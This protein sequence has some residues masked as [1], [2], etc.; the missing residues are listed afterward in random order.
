MLQVLAMVVQVASPK[1]CK[2]VSCYC[3]LPCSD[4]NVLRASV[5][6]R[7]CQILNAI[8]RSCTFWGGVGLQKTLPKNYQNCSWVWCIFSLLIDW[9]CIV[10]KE[11]NSDRVCVWGLVDTEVQCYLL[12][13]RSGQ[14]NR[15]DLQQWTG[16]REE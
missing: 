9:D 7:F 14:E 10:N 3:L 4:I 15:C 12:I 5:F 1:M 6:G 11:A 16:R 2:S 8:P 13:W